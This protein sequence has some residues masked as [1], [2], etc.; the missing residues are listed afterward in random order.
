MAALAVM[1]VPTLLL[2]DEYG[3]IRITPQG[4]TPKTVSVYWESG[5][6]WANETGTLKTFDLLTSATVTNRIFV[7]AGGSTSI[8]LAYYGVKGP[9]LYH[10]T[11]ILTG[12]TTNTNV[13]DFSG[14]IQVMPWPYPDLYVK[15]NRDVHLAP[16]VHNYRKVIMEVGSRILLSGETTL[17]AWGSTFGHPEAS[18]GDAFKMNSGQVSIVGAGRNGVAGAA[19]SAVSTNAGASGTSGGNGLPGGNGYNL[20]LVAHGRAD[21]GEIILSGG[22]GGD[23][24]GGGNG[25]VGENNSETEWRL[26]GTGG[27]GGSGGSGAV[28]GQGGRFRLLA[29]GE[30]I[31]W[32]GVAVDGGAG[33]TGGSRGH[34]GYG[35]RSGTG[36]Q[37]NDARADDYGL[38]GAWGAPGD[39]ANGGKGGTVDI[40]AS[41]VSGA[42]SANG[43]PGGA[44]RLAAGSMGG[45]GGSIRLL[46]AID[47]FGRF[48]LLGGAGGGG[49]GGAEVTSAEL[50]D[51]ENRDGEPGYS[52]AAGSGG[53][54]LYAEAPTFLGLVTALGGIGGSGGSGSAGACRADTFDTVEELRSFVRYK[55]GAAGSGGMGGHGGTVTVKAT[56]WRA[57]GE[58][59]FDQ[60][61]AQ[62]GGAGGAGNGIIWN[63]SRTNWDYPR[64]AAGVEGGIGTLPSVST[65]EPPNGLY[66]QLLV[67]AEKATT[68]QDLTYHI[69]AQGVTNHSQVQ[70][71]A[72]LPA[73]TTFVSATRPGV[74]TGNRVQWTFPTWS[75]ASTLCA[76]TVRVNRDTPSETWITNQARIASLSNPAGVSSSKVT[77]RVEAPVLTLDLA[78]YHL[79]DG[80]ERQGP[81]HQATAGSLI[82]WEATAL[83]VSDAP[84][85]LDRVYL[86]PPTNAKTVENS[87]NPA[88]FVDDYQIAW[89]A[90]I[91]LAPGTRQVFRF[92]S[93]VDK[94]IRSGEETVWL[95]GVTTDYTRSGASSSKTSGSLGL[96]VTTKTLVLTPNPE[97]IAAD[98]EAVSQITA[99]ASE[100][101]APATNVLVAFHTTLGTFL[102]GADKTANL[103]AL[104][105]AAGKAVVTLQAATE[106]G[107]ATVTAEWDLLDTRATVA[108]QK[109]T[110]KLT[111][112]E[113]RYTRIPA[114]RF[115]G[116]V[117]ATRSFGTNGI[118]DA[119]FY[120][121]TE[122]P[123]SVQLRSSDP[124]ADL[125]DKQVLLSCEQAHSLDANYLSFPA[126]VTTDA[127]GQAQFVVTVADLW[128]AK[129]TFDEVV[130]HAQLTE[131]A[132]IQDDQR[133]VWFNN[134]GQV[135]DIYMRKIPRGV[136]WNNEVW[137]EVAKISPGFASIQE[138]LLKRAASAGHV[139]NAMASYSSL[140]L[141]RWAPS[142]G[143]LFDNYICGNYQAQVLNLL[144]DL[145][146][147]HNTESQTDWLMNGL[148]YGPLFVLGGEHVAAMIYPRLTD[149]HLE[150][151][152]AETLI[153][154]PWLTQEPAVYTWQ[155]W[156]R[157][158]VTSFAGYLQTPPISCSSLLQPQYNFMYPANACNYP[159]NYSTIPRGIKKG[160]VQILCPVQVWIEDDQHRQTGYISNPLDGTLSGVENV[161]NAAFSIVAEDDGSPSWFFALPE[162]RV[163]LNLRTHGQGEVSL[164]LPTATGS[165]LRYQV[166]AAASNMVG[167]LRIDPA[168]SA[169]PVLTWNGTNRIAPEAFPSL[170]IVKVDVRTNRFNIYFDAVTNRVYSIQY[171][172]S[173]DDTDW[174]VVESLGPLPTAGPQVIS[175]GLAS[176]QRYYRL[177]IDPASR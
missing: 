148:D 159:D 9:G 27:N 22:A 96:N 150:W 146:V 162:T 103:T 165:L 45:S 86:A 74:V 54:T 111:A 147:N 134:L 32:G 29:V 72:D 51:P 13:V 82:E 84:V 163:T 12:N 173:L 175:D 39:G 153:L 17:V 23:G 87:L 43:G 36:Y 151:S 52:G 14:S 21:V 120:G 75:R 135:V 161:P 46:A 139:N 133:I 8:S 144:Y 10:Y 149:G 142:A 116:T 112:P 6:K 169:W 81:I 19:G 62:G 78:A 166:T 160:S 118:P 138:T 106:S 137:Q 132:T 117:T 89:S 156:N 102:T 98:G 141:A 105:D 88:G 121:R 155:T 58:S 171:R 167:Q 66:V 94:P 83:N 104:T 35:G 91:T 60:A 50:S 49:A 59:Q 90:P 61:P 172:S 158:L 38:V 140:V 5:V 99:I 128:R 48:S 122:I 125:S 41:R 124:N 126:S 28:G 2:G 164:L 71:S 55:G 177:K 152:N 129:P 4:V 31:F 53:G 130:I 65:N 64:G 37:T 95:S 119:T 108:F 85:T 93:L 63:A 11:R 15:A 67:D 24:G 170:A 79:L 92:R 76:L 131:D 7:P 3:L 101:G 1:M 80:G 18:L 100:N 26:G 68:G 174:T 42:M 34:Y 57:D 97:G 107:E 77:T 127:N 154:D 69:L 176:P 114:S 136:I 143:T 123:I 56:A 44:S 110:L 145:R 40:L 168:E 20:T 157:M 25:N 30:G 33:G 70:I 115:G 16:G 47:I 113:A 73:H 109:S